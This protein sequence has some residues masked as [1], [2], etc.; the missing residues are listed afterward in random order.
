MTKLQLMSQTDVLYYTNYNTLKHT[1]LST[2]VNDYFVWITESNSD[3]GQIDYRHD[4]FSVKIS[5]SII[6]F[7]ICVT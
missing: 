4:S 3:H 5:G 1:A 2:N 6:P 7:Y